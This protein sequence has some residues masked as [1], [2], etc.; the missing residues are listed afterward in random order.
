MY[1]ESRLLRKSRFFLHKSVEESQT[2]DMMNKTEKGVICSSLGLVTLLSALPQTSAA[3]LWIGLAGALT[4]YVM[5]CRMALRLRVDH[6]AAIA[7]LQYLIRLL[8][9]G[10]LMLA[11]LVAGI[12]PLWVLAGMTA[13]K[14]S[15]LIWVMK[16][17]VS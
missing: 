4:G 7:G 14:V 10:I 17:V 2:K 8:L 16:E 6:P 12:H 11:A 13:H 15:I 1:N 9:Y 5:I 3:G